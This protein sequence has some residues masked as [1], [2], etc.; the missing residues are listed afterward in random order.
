MMAPDRII[1]T[2]APLPVLVADGDPDYVADLSAF[3]QGAGMA[4]AGVAASPA[5]LLAIARQQPGAAVVSADLAPEPGRLAAD[6]LAAGARPVFLLPRPD[7]PRGRALLAAGAQVIYRHALGSSLAEALLRAGPPPTGATPGPRPAGGSGMAPAAAPSPQLGRGLVFTVWSPRGG[8]GKTTVA[9]G[10]AAAWAGWG[11]RTALVDLAQFGGVGPRLG[12]ACP[13]GKGLAPLLSHLQ[14]DPDLPGSP[15]LG[16]LL[17][18][19]LVPAPLGAGTAAALLPAPPARMDQVRAG[20]AEA[21]LGALA[22]THAVVVVDTS[23]DLA[24]RHLG[25]FAAADRIL[26]VTTPDIPCACQCLQARDLLQTLLLPRSRLGLVANRAGPALAFSL[27]E[28][29]SVAGLPLLGTLPEAYRRVQTEANRGRPPGTGALAR[30]CRRLARA[31]CPA[32]MANEEVRRFPW[33][34]RR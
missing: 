15:R 25:A 29:R 31:L 24:E 13:A 21:I 16:A 5:D 33:P 32:G 23:A 17:A 6:L 22:A 28:F 7:D 11:L 3:L 12:L 9:V 18:E 8:A 20:D 2:G 19:A 26:L 34:W 30:A 1:G 27:E 10:L 14:Q 4:V